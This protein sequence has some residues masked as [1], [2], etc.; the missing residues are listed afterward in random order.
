MLE[1]IARNHADLGR[2]RFDFVRTLKGRVPE[3]A[4]ELTNTHR[5]L[6]DEIGRHVARVQG[7]EQ[8]PADQ[9]ARLSWLWAV[10]KG[11]GDHLVDSRHLVL[12]VDE[13]TFWDTSARSVLAGLTA[14]LDVNEETPA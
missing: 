8:P 6:S 7:T 2:H 9:Q 4:T 12:G 3:Y 5:Q 13:E 10:G 11:I 14:S 1:L